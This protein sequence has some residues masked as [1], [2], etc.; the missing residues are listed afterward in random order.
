VD[1]IHGLETIRQL[2]FGGKPLTAY[3]MKNFL[4]GPGK[5]CS[6][7]MLTRAE[8]RLSLIGDTLFVCDSPADVGLPCPHTP[9]ETMLCSP[10]IGIDYAEEARDFPWRFYLQ[11]EV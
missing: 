2:R 1:P 8:N 4:N 10:R 6:G 7:F 3:R 9:K 11:K 5:V